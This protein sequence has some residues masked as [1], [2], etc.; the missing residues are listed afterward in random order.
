VFVTAIHFLP[1]RVTRL[2]KISPFGLLFK[3]PGYFWVKKWFVVGLY[4]VQKGVNVDVWDFKIE[5]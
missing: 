1:S 2:G 3:G 5:L 4:R